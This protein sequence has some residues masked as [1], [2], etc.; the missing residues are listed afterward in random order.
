MPFYLRTSRSFSF[1]PFVEDNN[2]SFGTAPESHLP[3]IDEDPFAHFLS[4]LVE[5]DDPWDA[6]SLSAG[7]DIPTGETASKTS[8]F[9]STVANK[10]AR[11]VKFNHVQLHQQYHEQE[12]DAEL[13]D[14]EFITLDDHRLDDQPHAVSQ[15]R[16][17]PLVTITTEPTRGRAQE[18][19]RAG[20]TGPRRRSS[21]TL[22]G[23]RH[24]WREPSPAL[25]TVDEAVEEDAAISKALPESAQSQDGERSQ[26]RRERRVVVQKARL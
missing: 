20:N 25:F 16:R 13:Q 23:R 3:D 19:V 5:E 17:P 18:L 22:S 10:W 9:K 4:P 11:Y 2:S 7:I 1:P 6:L 21:R 15:L 8:K 12:Q 26:Q 14:D 24:S